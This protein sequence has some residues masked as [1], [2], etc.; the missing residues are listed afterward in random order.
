MRLNDRTIAALIIPQGKSELLVF[1]DDL[2][3]FGLRLRA[4]G[5]RK[6]VFQ[7][8]HNGRQHRMTNKASMDATRARAWAKKLHHE[9]GL[10]GDPAQEKADARIQAAQTFAKIADDYLA[11]RER[12]WRLASMRAGRRYLLS[13]AKPLHGMELGKI[14]RATI[15]AQL[16]RVERESGAVTANR[17]RAMLSSFFNWAAREGLIDANPAAFTNKR[18]E[19]PRDRVLSDGEIKAIW[20]ALP[21]DD[22]G[23]IV[24][25]L[26][27]TGQ[28]RSE[29]ADLEWSEIS[30]ERAL[31]VLP[32]SRTKNGREHV[33]PMSEPVR[34]ILE[35]RRQIYG[36]DRVFGIRGDVFSFSKPRGRLAASIAPGT[37]E[38]PWTL[39]DLR[40]TVATGMADQLAVGPH[41]I[42]AV[43]N[44]VSGAKAGVAG[45][46][47]RAQYL[48][49]KKQAL[50]RW[51]DYVMALV[52]GRD[53]NVVPMHRSGFSPVSST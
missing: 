30:F 1:D 6:W 23:G 36:R 37:I 39:H 5:S 17:F 38:R 41:I 18:N 46:Y 11:F 44:H 20:N 3:G 49:E 35:S 51:A 4:G 32:A 21:A 47:N 31:I 19:T 24:K 53:V 43:L 26:L 28:R 12:E 9:V 34:A 45:T 33:V 52:E 10:G 29:I 15:A 40:R 22:F 2:P 13:H 48:A 50:D 25:L 14:D 8:R 27:L 7:Y 16:N 42:E